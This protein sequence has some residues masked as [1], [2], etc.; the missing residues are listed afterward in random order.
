MET[1][2]TV[3]TETTNDFFSGFDTG[4]PMEQETETAQETTEQ[5][6]EQ[7]EATEAPETRENTEDENTNDSEESGAEESA[8]PE[9]VKNEDTFDIVVD[10]KAQT[11]S[12]EEGIALMQKGGAFDRVKQQRD[13]A[14]DRIRELEEA[15][16]ATAEESTALDF[17]AKQCGIA[18][19]DLPNA[20]Y[21]AFMQA[22]GI[23]KGQADAEMKAF[24]LEQ[25]L[26]A[27]QEKEKAEKQSTEEAQKG[28][29]AAADLRDFQ[30][31]FPGVKLND[32][33]TDGV[34]ADIQ[35]GMSLA[36]AYQKY[37]NQQEAARLD[38]EKK[39]FA[40]ERKNQQNRRTS[41]GSQKT[42]GGRGA[43]TDDFFST[44]KID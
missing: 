25:Q 22:K 16:A 11:V 36:N 24:K 15:S 40:A 8:E 37:L 7:Q 31:M 44:F 43:A 18:R 5:E 12:R 10:G 39:Q 26:S 23:S 42:G 6:E 19:K 14:R 9:S 27:K 28:D 13:E 1:E 33:L 35:K 17:V 2:N 4:E 29:R 20:F 41:P 34:K 3:S 32:A 30:A 38:Q 21:T